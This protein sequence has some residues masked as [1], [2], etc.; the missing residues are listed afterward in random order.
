MN[1]ITA[2]QGTPAPDS[3]RAGRIWRGVL[4]PAALLL[5][6]GPPRSQHTP[7]PGMLSLKD[8]RFVIDKPLV[9]RK[10]GVEIVFRNGKV[11]VPDRLILDYYAPGERITYE[12][13]NAAER[14]KLAKGLVPFRGRWIKRS[15]AERALAKLMAKRRKEIEAQRKHRLWRNRSIVETK[16]FIF[17][18]NLPEPVFAELKVL[19]ETYLKVFL[20]KWRKRPSLKRKPR[21]VLYADEGDYHQISGAPPG[22]VGWYQP[23]LNELHL[24][25]DAEDP[26]YTRHVLFHETNHLLADMINGNFR[27]PDWI[28]E[29]MAEYYGASHWHPEEK[30]PFKRITV[31]HITAGRLAVVKGM[32]KE[33]KRYHL[34]DLIRVPDFG[35]RHYAWGWTFVHFVM[36]TKKYAKRWEKFY[37]DLAHKQGIKRKV[38]YG[39]QKTVTPEVAEALLIKYLKVPDIETLEKEWYAYI[40]RLKIDDLAG[41]E[42][43]ARTFLMLG[44][45]KEAKKYFEQAV[46]LGSKTPMVYVRYA[47]LFADRRENRKKALKLLAK[48][49]E[50]DPLIPRAYFLEGRI[51]RTYHD[52]KRKREGLRLL[53]LAAE[54]APEDWGY[55]Q[56]VVAAEQEDARGGDGGED[57]GR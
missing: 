16:D 23:A 42:A 53:K 22:V 10:G 46:R 9:R 34:K 54:M 28:E 14:A 19:F 38:L 35:A 12:P 55:Q 31:G 7:P 56:A 30:N 13:K 8:G 48:A 43:A 44:E 2:T 15:Q 24:Y 3:L 37:L 1:T 5:P 57:G 4:L 50:L 32:I 45:A 33:G 40:D 47:G 29:P 21:I 39:G 18:H 26:A 11:F 49:L 27:Y 52:A 6:A 36:S 41:A 25:W 17:E 51:L 20:K